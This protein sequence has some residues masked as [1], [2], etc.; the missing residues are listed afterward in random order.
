MDSRVIRIMEANDVFYF[1]YDV[2]EMFEKHKN[3]GDYFFF[4]IEDDN[5]EIIGYLIAKKNATKVH[6]IKIEVTEDVSN[7]KMYE[8]VAIPQ[9]CKYVKH[10]KNCDGTPSIFR[11][12]VD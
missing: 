1:N 3:E 9:F 7:K 4:V 12:S 2:R 6:I 11:V 8:K 10:I 5:E